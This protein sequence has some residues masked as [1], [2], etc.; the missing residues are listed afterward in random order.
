MIQIGGMRYFI[1]KLLNTKN[2]T[3]IPCIVYSN[4]KINNK[5]E[6]NLELVC[7]LTNKT[8]EQIKQFSKLKIIGDVTCDVDGSIPTTIKSTTIEEPNFYLNTETF[9]ETNKSKNNLAIMAVDNLPSELP[10]DSSTEFGNG[11]VNEVI[12]FILGKDDGR[13]LNSTITD[14]GSF[15]EKYNYLEDFINS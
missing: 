9:L 4:E 10:K 1:L 2:Y 6:I 5:N 3:K 13:I 8:K 14:K 12:P 15:L 7:K 11:I